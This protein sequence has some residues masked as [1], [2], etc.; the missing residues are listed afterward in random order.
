[1]FRELVKTLHIFHDVLDLL[2]RAERHEVDEEVITSSFARSACR[3]KIRTAC[4]A[5]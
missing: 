4:C 2:G 5:R 3:T 1:M